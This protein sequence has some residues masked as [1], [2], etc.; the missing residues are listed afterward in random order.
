MFSTYKALLTLVSIALLQQVSPAVALTDTGDDLVEVD[1]Q[2][3]AAALAMQAARLHAVRDRLL[4]EMAVAVDTV[5]LDHHGSSDVLASVHIG[6]LADVATAMGIGARVCDGGTG[7]V[8][9]DWLVVYYDPPAHLAGRF[10]PDE[11]WLRGGR[12]LR[13]PAIGDVVN[14]SML[15]WIEAGQVRMPGGTSHSTPSAL[16]NCMTGLDGIPAAIGRVNAPAAERLATLDRER[17]YLSCPSGQV[18]IGT[19]EWRQLST[20]VDGNGQSVLAES[21]VGPWEILLA[22]CRPPGTG[23]WLRTEACTAAVLQGGSGLLR[24]G[25]RVVE[26]EWSERQVVVVGGRD[27]VDIVENEASRQVV[28]PCTWPPPQTWDTNLPVRM[29][30]ENDE[31]RD[32]LCTVAYGQQWTL[33]DQHQRRVRSEIT[34]TWPAGMNVAPS[35]QTSW[36]P[37]RIRLDDCARLVDRTEVATRS[38]GCG[39]GMTG[40]IAQRRTRNWQE[41]LFAAPVPPTANHEHSTEAWNAWAVTG[42]SCRTASNNNGNGD[43]DSGG[44]TSW[45]H[46]GNEWNEGSPGPGQ[47]A[48]RRTR[49]N[50]QRPGDPPDKDDK[51]NG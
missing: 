48:T 22:D 47:T 21:A 43:G 20:M 2:S 30:T 32:I 3:R 19:I 33:G 36:S 23:I 16:V 25:L 38:V 8:S 10:P 13:G 27:R 29:V 46:D 18:G 45:W 26:M 15:A 11:V 49:N 5:I 12:M 7:D 41:K 4:E 39:S 50:G 35:T 28:V 31:H 37:W 51:D 6:H 1:R 17:R 9:D 24:K 14:A 34:L 40:S 42:N 44:D